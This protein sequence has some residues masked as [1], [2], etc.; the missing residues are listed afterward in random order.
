MKKIFVVKRTDKVPVSE[1]YAGCVVIC[2]NEEQARRVNP[3]YCAELSLWFNNSEIKPNKYDFHQFLFYPEDWNDIH[4][5]WVDDLSTLEV[6]CIGTA[7]P[8]YVE[9]KLVFSQFTM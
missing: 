8:S 4:P 1:S 2:D 7:D 6:T 9:D 3:A 5:S